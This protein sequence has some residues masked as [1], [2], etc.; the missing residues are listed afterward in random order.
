[1]LKGEDLATW[2][3]PRLADKGHPVGNDLKIVWGGN[4]PET[5][6]QLVELNPTGGAGSQFERTFDVCSL[7]VMTRGPQDVKGVGAPGPGVTGA[8]NLAAA[9]DSIFMDMYCPTVIGGK[10]VIDVDYVGGPP[11]FYGYDKKSGRTTYLGKYLLT[12]QR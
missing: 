10:R 3:T 1:M 9:V 11:A 6:D 7:Q 4:I 12:V 2:L 8:E 5:P